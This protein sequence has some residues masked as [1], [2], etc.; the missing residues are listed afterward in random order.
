MGTAGTGCTT[1]SRSG[2]SNHRRSS[3]RPLPRRWVPMPA[4]T[5]PTPPRRRRRPHC[6]PCRTSTQNCT[7][8][9]RCDLACVHAHAMP[10]SALTHPSHRRPAERAADNRRRATWHRL[11]VIDNV[12]QTTLQQTADNMPSQT[13]ACRSTCARLGATCAMQWA[14]SRTSHTS[15]RPDYPPLPQS[16][17]PNRC[18][19]AD[20]AARAREQLF[21]RRTS[22]GVGMR[23]CAP[24]SAVGA[25]A[26]S[27][28]RD[29]H[30]GCE[31]RRAPLLRR[32]HDHA[33]SCLVGV[34]RA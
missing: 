14:L 32:R 5:T 18:G 23:G 28:P 6:S 17:A 20:V 24:S 8:M 16:P 30:G 33:V 1:I 3:S 19:S 25:I 29:G 21:L 34:T 31:S 26:Q 2:S 11:H 9:L 10:L 27:V 7:H 12:Q 15:N 13:S 4:V 22:S